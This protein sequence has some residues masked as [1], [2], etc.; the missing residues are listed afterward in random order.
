[1]RRWDWA[2]PPP[3]V[4]REQLTVRPAGDTRCPPLLLVPDAGAGAAAFAPVWLPTAAER[5]FLASA[6]SLRGH[7]GSGDAEPR[8]R[9]LLRDYV[10]DVLQAVVALPVRPVL[11]VTGS[12]RW[13]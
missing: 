5:G 13:W 7:G 12:A 10:H 4:H 11:S 1:M 2:T 6:V 3:P 8:I 9:T